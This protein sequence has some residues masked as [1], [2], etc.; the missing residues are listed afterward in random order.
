M[1]QFNGESPDP[2]VWAAMRAAL[3][4][5]A[6]TI[7]H[8]NCV[9]L[10]GTGF[11][12]CG[13]RTSLA[14][15][16][17]LRR[18]ADGRVYLIDTAEHW[19]EGDPWPEHE[20]P[21]ALAVVDPSRRRV[22]LRRDRLGQAALVWARVRGGVV[23]ASRESAL[24]DHPDLDRTWDD[25]F[26]AAHFGLCD[27]EPD[28]TLFHG[29]HAVAPGASVEID[30]EG[31]RVTQ[32]KFDPDPEAVRLGDAVAIERFADLLGSA[33]ARCARP[34]GRLGISLS[35]GFDSSSILALLPAAL[36]SRATLAVNYGTDVAGSVDERPLAAALAALR[37]LSCVGIDSS[38]YPGSFDQWAWAPDPGYPYLNPYRPLKQAV[39]AAF[40]AAGVDL[41]LSGHFGD[42]WAASPA[43]TMLHALQGRRWDVLVR[44]LQRRF[45][46]A[47]RNPPWRDAALRQLVRAAL[48]IRPRVRP[49]DW[50]RAH[51]RPALAARMRSTLVEHDAWPD[52]AHAAY[53]FGATSA[54][55]AAF[56]SH[57]ADRHGL[58][59]MH[60]YRYWPLVRFALSLPAYMSER[61]GVSKWIGREALVGRLPD[62]WRTRPKQGDLLPQLASLCSGANRP[63]FEDAVRAGR[64][65]WERWVDPDAIDRR[66]RTADALPARD[67]LLL[68][69]A[70]FGRW[71]ALVEQDRR[72]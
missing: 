39:Y 20:P 61:D 49:P 17:A 32:A 51:W 15:A 46:A 56:E 43:R 55:D 23:V 69:L 19:A 14:D 18:G 27:P 54:L 12:A 64:D 62:A 3:L 47:P 35:A 60:P 34:V 50:I 57:Y 65:V 72:P 6:G 33:V 21:M 67:E 41:V 40:E 68:L 31:V 28:R 25:D 26:L 45:A 29:I 30:G 38:E 37:S 70:G 1:F 5:N 52:P 22:H 7:A 24:L 42:H 9:E 10:E 63:A 53:N 44:G 16:K 13:A 11:R 36:A 71:L 48:G 2:T 8:A 58:R 59:L 4:R 66:L